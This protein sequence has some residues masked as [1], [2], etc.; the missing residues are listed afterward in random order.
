MTVSWIDFSDID[1][2]EIIVAI[3]FGILNIALFSII[4]CTN[5][6]EIIRIEVNKEEEAP[7][8]N[9]DINLEMVDHIPYPIIL[10]FQANKTLWT[11]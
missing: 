3:I 9:N 11:N 5:K 2:Y 1:S 7:N 6:N 10:V 4:I 8:V